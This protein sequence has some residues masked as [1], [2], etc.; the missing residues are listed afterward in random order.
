MVAA[1]PVTTDLDELRGTWMF[2]S[3]TMNGEPI[4]LPERAMWRFTFGKGNKILVRKTGYPNVLWDFTTGP[5]KDAKEIDITVSP[6]GGT[7][8]ETTSGIYKLEGDSLTLALPLTKANKRP[9]GFDPKQH[10]LALVLQKQNSGPADMFPAAD[11]SKP[12]P[13]LPA[14]ESQLAGRWELMTEDAAKERIEVEFLITKKTLVIRGKSTTPVAGKLNLYHQVEASLPLAVPNPEG[15]KDAF[16]IVEKFD[17][18]KNLA[19]LRWIQFNFQ[20]ETLEMLGQVS[21]PVA[22]NINL[23]GRWK[24]LPDKK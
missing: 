5:G 9:G 22:E 2:K 3:G 13:K 24:R 18:E 12:K 21:Q 16:A 7:Q 4:K 8:P 17:K 6:G 1:Q 19:K 14:D 23:T 15:R 11:A 10:L 20:G